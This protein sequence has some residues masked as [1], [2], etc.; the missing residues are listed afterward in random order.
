[1]ISTSSA[2]K[3]EDCSINQVT[4]SLLEAR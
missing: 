4:I 2:S 1:N 3:T